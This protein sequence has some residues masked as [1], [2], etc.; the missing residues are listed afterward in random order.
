MLVLPSSTI[1]AQFKA[2]I[3]DWAVA[4]IAKPSD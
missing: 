3:G 4:S 2:G 1:R